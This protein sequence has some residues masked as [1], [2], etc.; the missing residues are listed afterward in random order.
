MYEIASIDVAFYYAFWTN[1]MYN[2]QNL[3]W[4]SVALSKVVR[5]YKGYFSSRGN[6]FNWR[7][8]AGRVEIVRWP[9]IR[10]SC[11]RIPE[12]EETL[13]RVSGVRYGSRFS[14]WDL[15]EKP[16]IWAWSTDIGNLTRMQLPNVTGFP[17]FDCRVTQLQTLLPWGSNQ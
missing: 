4:K 1:W 7:W 9:W 5:G 2:S 16:M 13:I 14:P 6:R 3:L 12:S 10:L 15:F 17:A 11:I 8:L